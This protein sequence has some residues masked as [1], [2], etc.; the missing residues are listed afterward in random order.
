MSNG[1]AGRP[2]G[3]FNSIC[4]LCGGK[5]VHG[6]YHMKL[7]HTRYEANFL[8]PVTTKPR[9]P[10]DEFVLAN[11]GKMSYHKMSKQTGVSPQRIGQ[12][13]LRVGISINPKKGVANKRPKVTA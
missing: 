6:D 7:K 13:A 5:K 11:V 10:L 3:P 8:N 2:P 4:R 9:G 1:K 12:I